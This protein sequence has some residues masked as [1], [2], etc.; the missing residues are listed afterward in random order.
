MKELRL[1]RCAPCEIRRK[2]SPEGRAKEVYLAEFAERGPGSGRKHSFGNGRHRTMV[3]VIS[4][5]GDDG[6]RACVAGSGWRLLI[7]PTPEYQ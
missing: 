4:A 2:G 7:A 6:A 1:L 5:G 3:I